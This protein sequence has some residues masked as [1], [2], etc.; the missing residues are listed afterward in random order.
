MMRV[1]IFGLLLLTPLLLSSDKKELDRLADESARMQALAKKDNHPLRPDWASMESRLR[2]WVESRLPANLMVLENEFP[3]LETRLKSE[4]KKRGIF[5]E[6]RSD[7]KPGYVSML[8]ILRPA[9]YRTAMIVQLGIATGCGSDVSFHLYRFWNGGWNHVFEARGNDKWG[10]ELMDT[11]FSEPDAAGNR[12][13][14]LSWYAVQ[15]GSVWNG[16]DYR[17]IRLS[18]TA[19][20]ADVVLSG[21]H[22]LV[23]ENGVH[24]KITPDELLLEM[25]AEAMEGGFRRTHVLQ[26]RFGE[27]GVERVDPVALQPQDFVHEWIRRPW[28]EMESRSSA[29]LGK[30]HK[31]L[32]SEDAGGA[33]EFVQTCASRPG[34]TQIGVSMWRIGERESPEPVT[35]C[36]LVEDQGGHRYKMAGVSLDRQPGCPGN[37]FADYDNLPS[38]F[39]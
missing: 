23:L 19:D 36:F 5:Q 15:C 21:A 16:V 14:Y 33:Y 30:W 20:R 2:E 31:F 8:K 37:T 34:F 3:G 26:Y 38:L 12:M 39:K 29:G 9:E 18:P 17:V 25:I 7:A 4:L 28:S 24:V 6:G 1:W 10:D 35:I 22:S 11:K 27:K 32:Y 13:L